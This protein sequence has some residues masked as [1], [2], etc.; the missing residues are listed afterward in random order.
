MAG[1]DY[2]TI[3]FKNGKRYKEESLYPTIDELGITFYKYYVTTQDGY[4]GYCFYD[5]KKFVIET[6]CNGVRI[7][8]RKL[9][10]SVFTA[11]IFHGGDRYNIIFGYGIDNNLKTW[12]RIKVMYL[13][14][15]GARKVDNWL[16]ARIQICT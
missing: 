12:D 3:V 15:R 11:E 6:V 10:D 1:I 5:D 8:A 9:L 13:G 16:R 7:K 4:D 14:K 2:G